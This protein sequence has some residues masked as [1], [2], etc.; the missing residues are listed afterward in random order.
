MQNSCD[1]HSFIGL[2]FIHQHIYPCVNHVFNTWYS[3]VKMYEPLNERTSHDFIINSSHAKFVMAIP[4]GLEMWNK[5]VKSRQRI[6][7]K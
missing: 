4:F 6:P 1:I 7:K 2:Y 3:C 5:R